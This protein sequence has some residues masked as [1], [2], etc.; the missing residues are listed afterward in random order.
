MDS[1]RCITGSKCN[2]SASRHQADAISVGLVDTPLKST[3]EGSLS[4]ASLQQLLTWDLREVRGSA[5][6]Q[7]EEWRPADV[8]QVKSNV[9]VMAW[10]CAYR[11]RAFQMYRDTEFDPSVVMRWRLRLRL[12]YSPAHSEVTWSGRI[13]RTF[14]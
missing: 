10:C 11:M 12:R 7:G 9:H 14:D 6:G 13:A 3:S 1:V 4:A 8:G 5:G 2:Q